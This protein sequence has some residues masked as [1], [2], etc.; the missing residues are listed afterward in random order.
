MI[1]INKRITHIIQKI[2]RQPQQHP[3]LIKKRASLYTNKTK[4]QK[5]LLQKF[6]KD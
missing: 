2:N 3:N 6:K 4:L 1:N 5:K